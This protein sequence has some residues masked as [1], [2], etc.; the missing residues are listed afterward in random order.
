MS[1]KQVRVPDIG[2]AETI[3]LVEVL[4]AEGEQ[5]ESNQALVVLESDKASVELPSA[6]SG[7]VI[8]I[9]VKAGESVREGDLLMILDQQDATTSSAQQ[10]SGIETKSGNQEAITETPQLTDLER[11]IAPLEPAQPAADNGTEKTQHSIFIPDLGEIDQAEIVEVQC[12]VGDDVKADQVVMLLESDKASME[13]AASVAGTV[14]GV[15]LTIGAEVK[16]GE[17]AVSM[18]SISESVSR[19]SDLGAEEATS[20]RQTLGRASSNLVSDE[21]R[22][23]LLEGSKGVSGQRNQ[24]AAPVEQRSQLEPA[25]QASRPERDVASQGGSLVHAGP[26]VRKL[27]RELGVDLAL[28]KGSGPNARILKEDIETFVKANLNA[29]KLLRGEVERKP[30]PDFSPFGTTVLEPLSK[31]RQVSAKHLQNSWQQIPHVTHFD[32]ADVTDLE[33]FRSTLNAQ[34]GSDAPKISPLAFFIKAVLQTLK[35]YP[36]F[37]ASLDPQFEHW[38]IKHYYNIGIAVETPDGLVVPNI[39]GAEALSI[40]EL[41]AAAAELAASARSKKLM[42]IDMQGGTF[43]ISSLGGIG[44]TGFTPIIN[45]PEI[46]ILGVARTQELPRYQDG[47]LKPRKILPLALSYDHRAID[48]AEAARFVAEISRQLTDIRWLAI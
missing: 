37:N 46:A 45:S 6:F 18:T 8:Q 5:V 29:P 38:V 47:E 22:Q 43:T 23:S 28:I 1:E 20:A 13:I 36:R 9:L 11:D 3:E 19:D 44:G 2:E 31:I 24:A 34:R 14:T 41:A 16:G 39:K 32:E 30:L 25:F 48:G 40:S 27:A 21:S 33:A 4:V 26:A 12:A 17:L 35:Q 42:P 10:G 15:H 7:V